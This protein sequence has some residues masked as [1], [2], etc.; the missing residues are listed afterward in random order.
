MMEGKL[1]G[2]QEWEDEGN[3]IREHGEVEQS[4]GEN[5]RMERIKE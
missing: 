5:R 4:E 2:E 1:W 3:G